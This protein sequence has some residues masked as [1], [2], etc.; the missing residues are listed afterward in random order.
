[1]SNTG[2]NQPAIGVRTHIKDDLM[3]LPYVV[4]QYVEKTGDDTILN[5]KAPYLKNVIFGSL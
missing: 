3:F 5:E 4:A 1:M 2:G